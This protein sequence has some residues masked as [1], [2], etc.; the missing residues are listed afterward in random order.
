MD[1]LGLENDRS[2]PSSSS[3][4]SKVAARNR[5]AEAFGYGIAVIGME[6]QRLAPTLTDPLSQA[7]PADETSGNLGV[8]PLGH[9]PG[10]HL[11]PPA[12]WPTAR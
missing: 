7:R 12:R 5:F 1:T 4:P 11:V 3:R 8:F 9:I 10:H 2:T 6:D